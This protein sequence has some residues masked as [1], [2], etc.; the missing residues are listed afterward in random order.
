MNA[1]LGILF[2]L[3]IYN[4]HD[5]VSTDTTHNIRHFIAYAALSL[6]TQ[7]ALRKMEDHS[8]TKLGGARFNVAEHLPGER[9]ARCHG[10]SGLQRNETP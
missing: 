10:P 3:A 1:M 4:K 8:E 6:F 9:S 5:I 2:Y 7:D